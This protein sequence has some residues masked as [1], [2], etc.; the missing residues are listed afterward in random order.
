MTTE[1]MLRELESALALYRA[2]AFVQHDSYEAE[3]RAAQA[4]ETAAENFVIEH[5]PALVEAVRDAGSHV[6]VTRDSSGEIVAVTRQD[7]EG[8]ILEVIAEKFTEE[9]R[10]AFAVEMFVTQKAIDQARAEGGAIEKT[11]HVQASKFRDLL[12]DPWAG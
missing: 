1:A 6:V 2:Y 11:G 5:G 8:R 9:E 10:H 12:P 3:G 4:F 7:D